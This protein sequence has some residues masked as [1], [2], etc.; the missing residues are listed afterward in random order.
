MGKSYKERPDKWRKINPKHFQK[1]R[2]FHGGPAVKKW[3]ENMSSSD[4]IPEIVDDYVDRV[5]FL[6]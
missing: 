5:D 4:S 3:V 1:K 2:K 6:Q